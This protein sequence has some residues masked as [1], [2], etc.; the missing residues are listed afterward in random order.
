MS[1]DERQSTRLALKL[2]DRPIAFHRCYVELCGN[3]TT[4]LFLSQAV[5]WQGVVGEGRW[6]YKTSK[7]WHDEIGISKKV[8]ERCRKSLR[9]LGVLREERRGMPRKVHFQV[10]L[11]KMV[12]VL[13]PSST[14]RVRQVVPKG[15]DSKYPKGTTDLTETTQETTVVVTARD[16][17]VIPEDLNTPEFL[18]AYEEFMAHRRE[19]RQA[20]TP[21][22][23]ARMMKRM[24]RSGVEISI[25]AIHQAIENGWTGVFPDRIK[26]SKGKT[27]AARSDSNWK[28]YTNV[29]KGK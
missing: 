20:V 22:A 25:Q 12:T 19:K 10:D 5:Y 13:L 4:A 1:S 24:Q 11:E 16:D 2:L 17:G 15:Y 21:I 23:H 26:R 14:Q 27:R 18:E 28:N 29:P 6:Y 8:Q 3:V 7:Q 9:D